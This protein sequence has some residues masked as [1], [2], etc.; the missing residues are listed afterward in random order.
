M[1]RGISTVP[2]MC[3]GLVFSVAEEVRA[4]KSRAGQARAGQAR[5]GQGVHE[6]FNHTGPLQV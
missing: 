1:V 2:D 4:G 5:P 3:V 6:T